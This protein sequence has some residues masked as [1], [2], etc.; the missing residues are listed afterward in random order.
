MPNEDIDETNFLVTK[1]GT[2]DQFM[3]EI[4]KVTKH[5]VIAEDTKS[6]HN[7]Y[8]FEIPAQPIWSVDFDKIQAELKKTVDFEMYKA[9]MP[10]K[11]TY[12]KFLE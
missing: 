1:N 9:V 10:I 11:V 4:E 5:I 8:T 6:L 7:R 2:L 3:Y 12:L